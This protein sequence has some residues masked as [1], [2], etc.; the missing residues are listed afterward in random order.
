[1]SGPSI[2]GGMARGLLVGMSAALAT[3]LFTRLHVHSTFVS[4]AVL[5]LAALVSALSG[6]IT[7]MFAK[8][9][10]QI[11]MIQTL[12]IAPLMYV[13]GVFDSL[14]TLPNWAQKLSFVNPMFYVVNALR[15]GALGV[16]DVPIGIA[17]SIM[18]ASVFVL[19]LVAKKLMAF[20]SGIRN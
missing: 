11:A 15:Y 3:L 14:S 9:F 5:L 1:M 16:S 7:A 2:R 12:V 10:D 6:F 20:G 17:L 8:S 13:G 19:Y 4:I 18:I